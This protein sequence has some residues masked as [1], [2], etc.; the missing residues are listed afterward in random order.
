MKKKIIALTA[1]FLLA[2]CQ[3]ATTDQTVYT[4]SDIYEKG[5][6][7]LSSDTSKKDVHIEGIIEADT[8][9]GENTLA[10]IL[11][12]DETTSYTMYCYFDGPDTRSVYEE[13][14]KAGDSASMTVWLFDGGSKDH[15]SYYGIIVDLK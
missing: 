15:P 13:R 7:L 3:A 4:V 1:A 14:K 12:S 5:S 9:A 2:G 10:G 8:L 6:E 11:V